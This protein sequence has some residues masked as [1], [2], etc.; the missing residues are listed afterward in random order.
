MGGS[1]VSVGHEAHEVSHWIDGPLG[2]NLTVLTE[3]R[4]PKIVGSDVNLNISTL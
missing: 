4:F 2:W 1:T 3:H